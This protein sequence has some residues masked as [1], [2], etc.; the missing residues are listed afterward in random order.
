MGCSGQQPG[1]VRVTGI[2]LDPDFQVAGLAVD[3]SW[4]YGIAGGHVVLGGAEG[5]SAAGR[6]GG[7]RSMAQ[8]RACCR[9][10]SDCSLLVTVSFARIYSLLPVCHVLMLVAV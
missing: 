3:W 6:E 5:S 1:L 8:H 10:S 7:R 4:R 2:A 9:R